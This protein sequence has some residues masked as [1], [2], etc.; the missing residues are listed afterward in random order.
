MTR[1]SKKKHHWGTAF[2]RT[3]GVKRKHKKN[4]NFL[5]NTTGENVSTTASAERFRRVGGNPDIPSLL[6][7][8]TFTESPAKGSQK[9]A[10]S[11]LAHSQGVFNIPIVI[12]PM[13]TNRLEKTNT[14]L[15]AGSLKGRFQDGNSN[16][17]SVPSLSVQALEK[18]KLQSGKREGS[19]NQAEE[20]TPDGHDEHTAFET[21]LSFAHNA[22]SH[23][24]KINVQDA[25]N[26]TISRNEP[27]DRKK[28]SSNIS[29]ALSE[30]STN[31]K[32]TS[33]TKES[34]G[35]FLKNLDNILA[36]S[37]SSTPSNQQLN[38]TE[39]GSK[40]K[41][42]SL[43]RL[44]F[45]N[46]KGHI[47]S[48]SHSSSNAISG[49]DTS[50]DDTRKM[51]DDMARKVVF[52]PIRHSHD[53]PTPGVGNLKLEHFDDSQATLEGLEAMSAE[54]LP[55]ADHLDSR[56]PVQQSNLERKTVP[57]KWSVVS[58]STTD[59]VKPRRRAKSMISAMAD[60][61]NTSSDVL[62]DCKKRLSF[63]S[64]NGLTNNDPEYEDREPREMSKKFLNRRSFSPGSIS[65]GMKVL[66]ST[67]LKYSLNK[68]KN[69]TDIAST[70]IPRPSM[71]NGRP[72]SGL[73]RSSSKSFSS[74]PVNIIEPSEENGRQSSIRIKGVEY[75][76]EK[77]DAEFHA[78]FKDSGVSPNERLILDHSCALSRDILL[79]GRMYISDQHIGFYSN[80]LGWVSTVFIP[81]KTIVQIE[82]RATAGIFPN[83]IVIDTLH[84]KYTFASFTSR[85][86]TYDLITEVWNQ[87]IL[88]KRF[89]SNSNNTN[90]S[91]NSI[92]D[93]ENDDYDD[94]Y[95]DYGDDDDDLYDNSNNISDST[96]ITSSVSIGK[97][98]DLPMPLQTDTPYGTGIPPL[99][100][101][102][103]SPTE[104]VYKPAPNEKLVNESTIHASLGRV[105][106]ILFGKDVSYIM[107]ILKAQKN[108]DISPIPV[109]VDS[110]TVSEG[111]KRDYSY[112]K[113][114]PGA[115]GPGKTKCMITET[116]QHFNLEEYVQ[117]LQTTKTPD[118][119]SG[120]SFYVRT[121]YLLSWANNNE[122]KLKV[123]VSVEW[124]GKSLI[125][126]PI[127]KG[128]FD[129]VTDATK[130][131]VE[132]LGNILTRS[133]TKRKRSSK[134][135][136]VTVST[137]PKMEPSSHA[138]TEPDIQ[139][140]KDDSIIRENE[141]IPAPLGTVVQLLFGS[142]TEYMQKVITR[143]KNNVNVETIPKFT[144]SLV[145]G[146]SRHY[147][148]TKKLNNSIGPKQTKCL[149]TESI[150]HM[151]IN[152]YVL[153]TQTTKTPDVPSGSNFAVES[154]I[155]LFWGQHDTTN[156]TVITKINWTSKSF[157]KG[158]IEK[159][160][161][162][163]Q[164]VSVDYMLSELR[165][166]ISRAKSKKPVKKV[167]KSHDK[168][169]PFHSKVEQKSSE[170]RKS[171]DNKD[172]LTHILDFVQN[173]F[174]SE[175]F[176]NNLLSPQ[177]LFLILGL[178]IMLFW[179][180]RLHVFQEKNN[181]QIIKPGRLLIDGQEY[182]Y[183]PSFGT[184]YN[185]YEN[186]ISSEKK[187]EN[188]NYARD[189]SPIVGRESDIWD[190]I[191][192]RGSAISPRGRAM[193]RNDDEHKLQQLSESIKITEMQLN[194]MKTMLD[195]IERDAN[196][197]S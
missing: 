140:D 150:E 166:I 76:S 23:I 32:N 151:D 18:E 2:L 22:V 83:G 115:I 90:S 35:P 61:Q 82:K 160:S 99:G 176:M 37:K 192:N 10:A 88:G 102:I 187:R 171:D 131:L 69:S 120:N 50:L 4:R 109:L 189:K 44:A 56:G 185:S 157:L 58:S 101:K 116:I 84:T 134:E 146:G 31:N 17:N 3:I 112:V 19:S 30:N 25:D 66:P 60:K 147:E 95:D 128:T 71:S 169:R 110:P 105:V 111:K 97:P 196:D 153:V 173:N 154:K 197:L 108:S 93:D 92:S 127:E 119:P 172:I 155:F 158:A 124:T 80:I 45:G 113:T 89:R 6:K 180:P 162:E 29:G 161:V 14:N 40:S 118:V 143:D 7:P 28:N 159:G 87:I 91:S 132:E 137:L 163:G 104:T 193:L 62:Q 78:I 46:L 73:R 27:K 47:H 9:A 106:N 141:N 70:I 96:D 156:M 167:M 15:T 107:A 181:L 75:A 148:Y 126:S 59:G 195:N 57:S 26:G 24:P 123:Y 49:D 8:E 12:D 94:D 65:M 103:H 135:N 41:P 13:E 144:P 38:T 98:E 164:K 121:V 79:Q 175:I 174:S 72:S 186:A 183:V 11:S 178:I 136:T 16:S 55:E 81:F 33:S 170:S 114:T 165:D 43:S 177:K 20:K 168:Q 34:D 138:P 142:N 133:A 149:L 190:W 64:S 48:N 77:K 130:I 5:N 139:K 184:L 54:S 117:V 51:T 182:N 86:A 52:E 42:S 74:T 1:D 122:T 39:A 68:V 100:P 188:V 145:E 36:A 63:N 85:D 129:G 194:H 152:N 53:K 191:S 21:F 125:K 67:A 179:S